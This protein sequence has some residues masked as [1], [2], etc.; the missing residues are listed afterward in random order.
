MTPSWR[1]SRQP[2]AAAFRG[3][4]WI[5]L[6][7]V[8]TTIGALS[9]QHI[10]TAKLLDLEVE[11][12][13]D[14]QLDALTVRYRDGGLARLTSYI[15]HQAAYGPQRDVVYVLATPDGQRLAGN[16]MAWPSVRLARGVSFFRI[17]VQTPAGT[18]EK[19]VVGEAKAL[20]SDAR[21]LV[22][23]LADSR[24]ALG[25]KYWI[26]LISSVA[27][28]AC[29]SLTLGWLVSRRGLR[30]IEQVAES[31]DRFL[32]GRLDE[33]L[34]VS[35]R[36]DEFDRLAEVVNACF[37]ETERMVDS[38]RAATDG[39]AH[40]LKTPLT[41]I[42]ARIELAV[43]KGQ[44][45]AEGELLAQT[46]SDLDVMLDLMNGLLAL[47]RAEATTAHSFETVDL[48]AVVQDAVDLYAPLAE[49]VSCRLVS[50]LAPASIQGIRPLLLHMTANLID[51]A[52]KHSPRG[53]SILVST[54]K[55]EGLIHLSIADDGPGIPAEL[56]SLALRRFGRLDESRSTTGSG[57]GLALVATVARVHRG[58]LSL[59][60]NHPGL[61][62]EV[63]F[64][65]TPE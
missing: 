54:F 28:T 12:L 37:E 56:R 47:A 22:G 40:D 15:E 33:R 6:I 20:G 14:G 18:R 21:V 13:I 2:H 29:L 35:R 9:W 61:L 50:D 17:P 64:G 11:H 3:A 42:K 65:S 32:S 31:G 4:L 30:F 24:I 52:I 36:N 58:T 49:D 62:A 43:I 25:R 60:D 55:R 5:T 26:S 27:I 34:R 63:C 53:G 51:N 23:H 48:A 44:A 8:A 46:V 16:G 1:T 19:W 59:R 38:L 7:A 57:L 41:R 45:F 39:L 10:Q